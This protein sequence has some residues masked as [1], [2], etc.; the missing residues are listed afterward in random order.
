MFKKKKKDLIGNCKD[1][2]IINKIKNLPQASPDDT[3]WLEKEFDKL[4]I[5]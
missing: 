3:T 5:D 4:M 1:D 2:S